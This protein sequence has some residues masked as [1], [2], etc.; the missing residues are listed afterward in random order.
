MSKDRTKYGVKIKNISAGTLYMYNLGLRDMGSLRKSS[1][2]AMLVNSLLLDFLKE[3]G[4]KIKKNGSTE[5]VIGIDF[6]HKSYSYDDEV[7]KLKSKISE[8]KAKAENKDNTEKEKQLYNNQ[9]EFYSSRLKFAEENSSLFCEKSVDDIRKE[10]YND[11][12]DVTYNTYNKDGSVKNSRVVHYKML[13]RSAGKA[14][15]GNCIFIKQSLWEKTHN[16]MYMGYKMP[17]HNAPIVEM[18]VYAS[19]IASGIVGKIKIDPQNILVIK[20]VD[21]FFK[22]DV[23]SVELGEDK[24]CVAIEKSN[25]ELKNTL[26]DGQGLIDSSIFPSWGNGYILL[27]H[28]LTKFAVFNTNIQQFFKDYYG[29]KYENAIINDYWGNPHKAKDIKIITT[30]NAMKWMKFGIS[31]DY[32][33]EKVRENGCQ[34][35]VVKTAHMSKLGEVQKMSYQMVNTLNVDIMGDVTKESVEYIKKLKTDKE[36]FLEYINNNQN[37]SNDFKMLYDLCQVNPSF[38][39]S[40]Y[41]YERKKEIIKQ[42]IQDFKTGKIIQNADNLVIVG[43]PYAM[44]LSS[45][46]EDVENDDTFYQEAGLI[47]CYTERFDDNEY[48]AS[49]RSPHNSRNNIGYLHNHYSEHMQKYFNFGKQIIAVN[50]IHTDFQDRHNGSDQ[51]SDSIYV[52]NQPQIADWAKYCYSHHHTIVNNIPK[53]QNTYDY[54]MDSYAIVDNMLAKYQTAIG[55]SSNIAQIAQSYANT[56]NKKEYWDATA[57][58]S[59]VAQIAIDSAKRNFQCDINEEINIVRKKINID[60]NLYPVFWESIQNK[61]LFKSSKNKSNPLTFSVDKIN[62]ELICP[63][64]ELY[65]TVIPHNLTYNEKIPMDYFFEKF[66]QNPNNRYKCKKVE[67]LIEKYS[68]DVFTFRINNDENYQSADD[69]TFLLMDDFDKLIED[70]Q[71]I[72]ISNNYL[73]LFSWLIDRAFLISPSLKYQANQ[74]RTRKNRSLLLKTLYDVNPKAVIKCFC[75]NLHRAEDLERMKNND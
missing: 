5:D 63:M 54:T 57:I 62:K 40:E 18:G 74:S 60:E 65:K 69:Q 73:D 75:K 61:K 32:W 41:F 11:G 3:N 47:Q 19:L 49:F 30:E 29:D 37:F 4:L 59:V 50:M 42:Y 31:Y 35:G 71:E 53:S 22:T 72:Y 46:G 17:K 48:L 6:D 36:T 45:V 21:S 34:F 24:H 64:N 10:F 43:S 66:E 25:Y 15:Q 27:R 16:F 33:C 7:K 58:L 8:Y 38:F 70:I 51:D 12:V 26:F 55:Q 39:Y 68:A 44:L 67:E 56:F 23:V 52:T 1:K 2:D 13:Y 14:K 20:D 28:H 9:V